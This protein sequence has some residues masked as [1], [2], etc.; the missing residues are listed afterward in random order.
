[1]YVFIQCTVHEHTHT[2][3]CIHVYTCEL[4]YALQNIYDII[5]AIEL[6]KMK[7]RVC[8][9]MFT[10]CIAMCSLLYIHVGI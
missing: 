7:Y 3:T 4:E 1:M 5:R 10:T 2:H 8:M 6:Y 9:C